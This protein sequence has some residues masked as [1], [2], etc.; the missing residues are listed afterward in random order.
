MVLSCEYVRTSPISFTQGA[1]SLLTQIFPFILREFCLF[2]CSRRLLGIYESHLKCFVR[3]QLI[4]SGAGCEEVAVSLWVRL[5]PCSKSPQIVKLTTKKKKKNSRFQIISNWLFRVYRRQQVKHD[6]CREGKK[7]CL[8]KTSIFFI[9]IFL[10]GT[11]R[12]F[13]CPQ[14]VVRRMMQ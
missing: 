5:S 10:G 9:V 13:L 14:N 4:K 7:S 12:K 3:S 2:S 1:R 8:H 6:Q 11:C